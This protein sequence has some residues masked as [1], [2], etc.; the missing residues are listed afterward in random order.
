M[1]LVVPLLQWLLLMQVL[2]LLSLLLTQQGPMMW[3]PSLSDG[4]SKMFP[5]H[6]CFRVSPSNRAGL[7]WRSMVPTV[8]CSLL[9]AS[10]HKTAIAQSRMSKG[11]APYLPPPP[12]RTPNLEKQPSALMSFVNDVR[13]IRCVPAKTSKAQ[14][15]RPSTYTLQSTITPPPR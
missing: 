12:A 8:M 7:P 4:H 14:R 9:G 2:M 6:V 15:H 10:Q 13:I 5:S 11:Q 3:A 1:L